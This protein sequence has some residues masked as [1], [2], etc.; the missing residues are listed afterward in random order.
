ML[1]LLMITGVFA[2]QLT[3]GFET[4]PSANWNLVET[5]PSNSITQSSTYAHTGTY[6]LR[7]SSYSSTFSYDQYIVSNEINWTDLENEFSFYHRKYTYGTESIAVGW[8][9][10]GN[11]V[12]SDFTWSA[13]INPTETWTQYLKTD[14]PANTKY[15]AIHYFSNYEYY[16]Y[17]DDIVLGNFL[18]GTPDIP[19]LVSPANNAINVAL[20]A[21]LE[22]TTG[23][24][25][26]HSILYLADNVGFTGATIVNPAIS[27][28]STSLNDGT[29]YFWKVVAVGPTGIETTSSVNRFTTAFLP[30][31]EF[32]YTEGFEGEWV[33]DPAA[34]LGW[35]QI[36]VSGT[37]VWEQSATYSHSGTY[38]ADGPDIS[39]GGEHLLITPT[40][41]F[42]AST[43]YRL[44]FWL[45]GTN[46][47]T[48]NYWTNLQVQITDG[49]YTEETDFIDELA[50]YV[51]G[52]NMPTTWEEQIIIL[53]DYSGSQ[54][55]AF[56]LID[57][58]GY[59]IYIDDVT[60]EEIPE[61]ALVQI[62]PA[63]HDFG[64]VF[65]DYEATQTF[66]I[67]NNGV[68]ATTITGV[69][70]P[71]GYTMETTAEIPL[72]LE[73]NS[74]FVV[75]VTF[76]PVNE[77]VYSG[78]L[79]V[80]EPTPGNPFVTKNTDAALTGT[81]IPIP[82]GATCQNPIPLTF[83]A[84]DVTG[85]TAD[86]IDDYS[87]SWITPSS[88]YLNGDDV[89]YQFTLD[90]IRILNGYITTSQSWM[91]AFILQDEPNE[92]N[93]APV[94]LSKTSSSGST[95]TYTNEMLDV[96][97][98]YLIISSY[99]SPQSIDYTINLTAD[100]LPV[101]AA[102][103]SP[104]PTHEAIDQPTALTL[105]WTN[106]AYT[107]TIDLWFGEAGGRSMA[108][109]LDNVTAVNSYE[110]TDL[111]PNTAYN[112]KVVNRNYS[113]ETVDTLIATWSFTTV[114]SAPEAVTYT[115]PANN[116]TNVAK[117]GNLTWNSVTGA[118]GYLV[119]FSEDESFT[120]VTPVNQTIRTYAYNANF[121]TTYY[122]KVIPYNVVGQ[123][124]EGIEV[125]SF[126]TMPS[127]FPDADLVFDGVRAT[128][129]YMPLTGNYAYA[130]TQNIYYQS[131]LN[132]EGSA[133]TSISYLYNMNTA[134]SE[135]IEI[136]M[137]H[138]DKDVFDTT[139]DWITEGF[140]HVFSGTMSVNTT[141]P[142]V[143]LT[144]DTPFVYNNSDNLVVLFFATQ[145]GYNNYADHFYNYPVVGNRS[146]TYR[147]DS[148]NPYTQWPNP[149][150]TASFLKAYI[151]VTGFN[152]TEIGEEPQF[153]VS[154]EA[155]AFGEQF[156]HTESAPQTLSVSNLGLG[157]LSINSLVLTGADVDQFELTDENTYPV[158]LGTGDNMLVSV[159]YAPI[160]GGEHF[161]E[162]QITDDQGRA[163]RVNSTTG[164]RE[165][166]S[167]TLTGNCVDPTIYTLPFTE[168]FEENNIHNSGDVYMWS[169]VSEEGSDPWT[170]NETHTDYNRT[171]RTGSFN[172]TLRYGNTDWLMRAIE[173][174]GGQEYAIELYTRQDAT[175]GAT[176]GIYYGTEA[177]TTS[178][179]SITGDIAVTSGD[180]QLI[181]GTFTPAA[182][183]IYYIGIKGSATYTPWYISVDD[184]SISQV[185]AVTL[186][187]PDNVI[188]TS[189][190]SGL[191]ITWDPVEGANSY[192]IY[193][194]DRRG[195]EY[196][197]I[198]TVSETSYTPDGVDR[199]KLFKIK[200]S[201]E[202]I[203][204]ITGFSRRGRN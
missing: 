29:T 12:N 87:S 23:D 160:S 95:L 175:S 201:P 18:P 49:S 137:G 75:T 141:D 70:V 168:G 21:N 90:N 62:T 159:V 135:T 147:N 149:T 153:T 61:G 116:A 204:S 122:W 105:G 100:P 192:V 64:D 189:T 172:V 166:H 83:P 190:E 34:P 69:D 10:T 165:M 182:S 50:Y 161:A 186:A 120:S 130:M 84:V 4:W 156:A 140:T 52:E 82:Q 9:T 185:G 162:I 125:W 102:A 28:Y 79:R 13:T 173:L 188:M 123:P 176:V 184:I 43:N 48:G 68:L 194:T 30:I 65:I 109:V 22:W 179:E 11:D 55:I 81:G 144:L 6:S 63:A 191:M 104:S 187:I 40:F 51:Q 92:A 126:T 138:T 78:N 3:D 146:I 154:A 59:D 96:G 174:V 57:S 97:T 101:P 195:G 15:V 169:Q 89:V 110:V 128:G 38:S 7:F 163:V 164:N 148:T 93:P 198:D 133:I 178:M 114:G 36:S 5:S 72:T 71:T 98:Y 77:M 19:T 158:I 39:G 25:T 33:G 177:T 2:Q 86:Y 131:E 88:N 129:H 53:E 196:E 58:W 180:Y 17:I 113:G 118:D 167:V 171:P 20:D 24:N 91:G 117:T 124:T 203:S 32:P 112:W 193:A 170:I 54:A 183:G 85:N 197:I 107:E 99:P 103:T 60:I 108:K 202:I 37:N 119:Y 44:R 41:D 155:L 142:I 115:A 14:L 145:P 106:A 199:V 56:R 94:I 157:A 134:W 67:A 132:I 73:P 152:Y 181:D 66:T 200:A 46:S 74:S 27:P 80:K 121:D 76:T 8:S 45:R 47:S 111:S 136:F 139:T 26:D 151:P 16:C 143:A 1:T 150:I 42:D 35:S 127:P 31:T